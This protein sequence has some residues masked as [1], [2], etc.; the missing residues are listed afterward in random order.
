MNPV[1]AASGNIDAHQANG[2]NYVAVHPTGKYLCATNGYPGSRHSQYTIAADGTLTL[3][4]SAL[5]WVGTGPFTLAV[6]MKW[7]PRMRGVRSSGQMLRTILNGEEE[8]QNR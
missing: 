6:W 8:Y 4:N 5:V 3:M 2:A 1:A 7:P